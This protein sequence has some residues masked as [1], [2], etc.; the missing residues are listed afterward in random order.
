MFRHVV[1]F[2]LFILFTL[3]GFINFSEQKLKKVLIHFVGVAS[4]FSGSKIFTREGVFHCL[5]CTALK[6]KYYLLVLQNFRWVNNS[7]HPVM[8]LLLAN[9]CCDPNFESGVLATAQC[10]FFFPFDCFNFIYLFKPLT[11]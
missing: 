1:L 9:I 10:N 5:T 3:V 6:Q 4:F 11:R 8:F 7:C 2:I